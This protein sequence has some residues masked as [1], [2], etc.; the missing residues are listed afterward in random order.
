M[1]KEKRKR[2]VE[3]YNNRTIE[4]A[5]F[6]I[7]NRISGRVLL[8]SQ[9][10]L[11]GGFFQRMKDAIEKKGQCP[12]G[13]CMELTADWQQLGPINFEFVE[14]FRMTK[15]TDMSDKSFAEEIAL[16]E[17]LFREELFDSLY[18]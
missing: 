7:R 18:R 17:K 6:G 5:V 3:N 12:V 8:M 11:L 16:T 14:Y 10:D 13:N 15:E 4:G 9:V 2:L 1:D